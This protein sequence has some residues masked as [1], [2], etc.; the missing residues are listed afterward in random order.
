MHPQHLNKGKEGTFVAFRL[1]LD[2]WTY[3][4][5][6]KLAVTAALERESF[7]TTARA[8]A[9]YYKNTLVKWI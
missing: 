7:G 6:N 2:G 5:D 8:A 4:R 9:V 1:L 3:G